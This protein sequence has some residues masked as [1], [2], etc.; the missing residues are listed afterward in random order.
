MGHAQLGSPLP[1]GCL[2]DA[3]AGRW[4]S[5]VSGVLFLAPARMLVP[6][7]GAPGPIGPQ[8]SVEVASVV[9]YHH[10]RDVCP[11]GGRGQGLCHLLTWAKSTL[12]GGYWLEAE[13]CSQ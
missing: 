13:K 9:Q 2:R 6:R 11:A 7:Q 10:Q 8:R 12:H 4:L 5:G 1:G 3:A